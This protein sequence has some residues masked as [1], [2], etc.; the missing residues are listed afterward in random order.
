MIE[1]ETRP[2]M[3]LTATIT[4]GYMPANLKVARLR[5]RWLM[6]TRMDRKANV[7]PT[8]TTHDFCQLAFALTCKVVRIL[9]DNGRGEEV[10][11]TERNHPRNKKIEYIYSLSSM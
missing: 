2:I 6:F 1:L 7:R 3:L 4:R 9:F 5:Q 10:V 8:W 11:A